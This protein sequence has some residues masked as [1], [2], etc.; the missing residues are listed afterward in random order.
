MRAFDLKATTLGITYRAKGHLG[1][2]TKLLSA[3]NFWRMAEVTCKERDS[4][5]AACETAEEA[6]LEATA[7]LNLAIRTSAETLGGWRLAAA[8]AREFAAEAR[9]A[10]WDHIAE[11]G[12]G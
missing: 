8:K 1:A 12:C 10:V 4:L 3:H 7:N 6:F 11:H 9:K 2:L 5:L